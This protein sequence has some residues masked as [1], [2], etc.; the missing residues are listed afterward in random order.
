MGISS[1]GLYTC[2]FQAKTTEALEMAKM[3]ATLR[4]LC[5]PSPKRGILQ[6][7]PEVR[8]QW[9]KGGPARKRLLDILVSVQGDKAFSMSKAFAMRFI[10]ILGRLSNPARKASTSAWSICEGL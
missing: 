4:R 2:F 8:A 1:I 3:D 9:L 7:A 6:V 10:Y 5:T